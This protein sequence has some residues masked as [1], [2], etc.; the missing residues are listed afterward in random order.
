VIWYR[1]VDQ[2]NE[3]VED[4]AQLFLGL[5]IQC[6]RCHHHPFEKWS[7]DDYYSLSAFFSRVGQK[8]RTVK[9]G[10]AARDNRF[11]RTTGAAEAT[12]PRTGKALKPAGL[13]GKHLDIPGDRDPRVW[14]ADW[15]ADKTNPFFAK[16]VVNRYWKHFSA[17][18]SSSR[19]TMRETNPP[20][21]PNC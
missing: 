11:F 12:N 13:G 19:K 15:M 17:T 14:L 18:A 8:P 20:S 16:S 6:A 21:N 5:R 9:T 7:Q 3:Q 4:T 10:A 2:I 1:E